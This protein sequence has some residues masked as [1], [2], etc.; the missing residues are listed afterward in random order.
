M[1]GPESSMPPEGVA[2]AGPVSNDETDTGPLLVA[3]GL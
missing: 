1:T 3:T 2:L